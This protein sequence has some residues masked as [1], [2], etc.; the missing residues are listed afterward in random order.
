MSSTAP[1]RRAV[2]TG[3]DRPAPLA[4]PPAIDP[5]EHAVH[6]RHWGVQ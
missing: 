1:P 5:H 3:P 6:S 4:P 2:Q